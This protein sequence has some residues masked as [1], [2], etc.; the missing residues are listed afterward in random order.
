MPRRC[1][2]SGPGVTYALAGQSV[3]FITGTERG[4][5]GYWRINE[6]PGGMV[7]DSSSYYNVGPVKGEPDWTANIVPLADLH[8]HST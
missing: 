5:V 1:I 4:L 8:G 7:F 6:G 3:F 2:I